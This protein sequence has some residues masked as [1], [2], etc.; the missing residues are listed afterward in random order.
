MQNNDTQQE[1][2]DGGSG[3]PRVMR[4]EARDDAFAAIDHERAYQD[5]KWGTIEENPH[6]VGEWLFIMKR[7]LDEAIRAWQKGDCD[8]EAMEEVTQVAAV[9]VACM[10]QHG[11]VKRFVP[12]V[13][14]AMKEAEREGA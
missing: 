13:W 3:T 1:R 7:E 9:A 4:P 5:T 12:D 14:W 8:Y 2:T 6:T 10:E 11:P